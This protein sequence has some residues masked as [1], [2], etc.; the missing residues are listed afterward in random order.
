[1]AYDLL[2]EW[3]SYGFFVATHQRQRED[4]RD[5]T[6][7]IVAGKDGVLDCPSSG[8]GTHSITVTATVP[9]SACTSSLSTNVTCVPE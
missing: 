1:M 9:G 5:G 6:R 4:R 8:A 2:D 3:G 7:T